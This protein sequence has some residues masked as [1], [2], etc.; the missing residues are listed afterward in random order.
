MSSD[1]LYSNYM[2]YKADTD[3]VATWL[4]DTAMGRCYTIPH[5]FDSVEPAIKGPRLKG[6]ARTLAR[7]SHQATDVH[8]KLIA[9]AYHI[10][11]NDFICLA[12]F[13]SK[14][15]KPRVKVPQS[16]V[17]QLRQAIKTRK[18]HQVGYESRASV[19]S[20]VGGQFDESRSS[21]T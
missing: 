14:V 21:V 10:E 19:A 16:F 8:E 20:G 9:R 2:R 6:K 1:F 11:I 7:A 13:I 15:N 18:S 5:S 12:E 4:L 3:A 17:L